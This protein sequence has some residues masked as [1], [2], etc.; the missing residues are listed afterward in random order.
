MT[1]D[2]AR[3]L[4]I[5][6]SALGDVCRTVPLAASLRARW[7]GATIDWLVQDTF[8][9]AVRGHPAV[10]EVIPFPRSKFASWYTP[11]TAARFVQ[12]LRGLRRRRYDIVVDAQGLARSALI[13]WATGAPVRV[14]HANAREGGRLAYTLRV[15]DGGAVHTV[16]RMLRLVE[17]A[18]APIV[19]DMRLYLP[20]GTDAS[21]APATD[22]YAVLAPTSRWP[23]KQWPPQRFAEL[24]QL[25]L[26]RPEFGIERVVVVGG[27]N[28]RDQCHDVLE[29]AAKDGCVIDRVGHTSIAELMAIIAGC[30]V[31]VAN[32]SAALHMAVGF[33]RP[34]VGLYGPTDVAKVGPYGA[35]DR[36]IQHRE[37]GDVLD[38]KSE[39]V[40]RAMM[41]RITVDEV[42]RAVE[43][44]LL[45]APYPGA[46]AVT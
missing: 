13:T 23:G 1:H 11:P 28:E 33:G 29:L 3:I 6:P 21:H 32:D 5:R 17:A 7:P 37:P 27:R 39:S 40:G 19:R 31:L 34:L 8:V 45:A 42:V 16:D 43:R 44:Q 46:G 26:S 25:L 18:G 12:W 24:A 20:G 35:A 14:G 9:D 4:L 15:D 30:R 36:V 2:P 10:N 41:A 22:H 38:H